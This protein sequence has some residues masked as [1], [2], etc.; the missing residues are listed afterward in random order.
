MKSLKILHI[1]TILF[2]AVVSDRLFECPVAYAQTYYVLSGA[3]GNTDGT[4]WTNAFT[5]L[6][7]S[8]VRGATYYIGEGNYG[9]Y[10]FNDPESGTRPITIKKATHLEHGTD[11]G[12]QSAFGHGQ[13]V[14]DSW[15]VNTSYWVFDGQI[16]SADQ[17]G[18]YG[19]R[20]MPTDCMKHNIGITVQAR[21]S[22]EA[23]REISFTHVAVTLC[24]S[25]YDYRQIGIDAKTTSIE[26]GAIASSLRIANNYVVG[27]SVGVRII[28]AQ[29]SIIENNIF[30]PNWSSKKNH[31][32]Q[33]IANAAG[34]STENII[35]R[36][37]TFID[38][39][40]YVIDFHRN[41]N[42]NWKIYN[43]IVSGGAV[44]G[45]YATGDSRYP[46]VV[47]SMQIHGNTHKNVSCSGFN[48]IV[49]PGS[50]TNPSADKSFAYNNLQY[51]NKNCTFPTAHVGETVVHDYNAYFDHAATLSKGDAISEPHVQITSGNPFQNHAHD[52][53]LKV[54]TD[55]GLAL[56]PP[57][58]HDF[59]GRKRGNRSSWIRG[60]TEAH[61]DEQRPASPQLKIF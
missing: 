58:D 1:A 32:G 14:F 9:S 39:Q 34:G 24:G 18:S 51:N 45:I 33:L 10:T 49:Y 4:S 23:M 40:V 12:W 8:L 37:N 46:N 27:G 15:M 38:S 36:N 3:S 28:N 17:A 19:F 57:Y 6:P 21:K 48:S 55:Q 31:G 54:P 52:S 13:A 43:N 41:S 7:A 29:D 61:T 25:A 11:T 20:I 26:G 16:G 47:K 56:P 35:V 2:V 59:H 53:G 60:A 50:L 22:V 44:V 5:E 30:G 42:S